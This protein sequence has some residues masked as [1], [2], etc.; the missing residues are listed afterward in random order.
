MPRRPLLI[1]HTARIRN[2]PASTRTSNSAAAVLSVAEAEVYLLAYAALRKLRRALAAR[3][4]DA[5]AVR[6]VTDPDRPAVLARRR[7]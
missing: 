1:G 5:T 6:L 7:G 3:G 2:T 4:V